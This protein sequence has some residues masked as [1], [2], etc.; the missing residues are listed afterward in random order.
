M[1]KLHAFHTTPPAIP[2]NH[3]RVVFSFIVP[4]VCVGSNSAQVYSN[5]PN[6]VACRATSNYGCS[7]RV[8]IRSAT[9]FSTEPRQPEQLQ[10]EN[11]QFQG[12]RTSFLNTSPSGHLP[13]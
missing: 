11:S 10:E 3:T 12:R 9:T 13:G 8:A 7:R 5:G 4:P 6:T 1:K 2:P